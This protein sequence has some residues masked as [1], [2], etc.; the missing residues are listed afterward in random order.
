MLLD[1]LHFHTKSLPQK[2]DFLMANFQDV[3]ADSDRLK[4]AVP[5]IVAIVNGIPAKVAAAVAAATD[6]AVDQTAFDALAADL[7]DSTD[8]IVA[9]VASGN[10]TSLT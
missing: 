9:L 1:R 2:L 4:A 7:K 10:A 8:K 6:G 5:Q 3:K